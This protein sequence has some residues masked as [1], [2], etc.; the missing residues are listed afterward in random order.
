MRAWYRIYKVALLAGLGLAS[1]GASHAA[2]PATETPASTPS[3]A[4]AQLPADLFDRIVSPETVFPNPAQ[5]RKFELLP[6]PPAE[7]RRSYS[8]S[9]KPQ[10]G[11]KR[12][13]FYVV[14]VSWA[15]AGYWIKDKSQGGPQT[16]AAGPN[17]SM[18]DTYVQT[19]DGLYDLRVGVA[20]SSLPNHI[21]VD[22]DTDAAAQY[23]TRR[24]AKE[25]NN[26]N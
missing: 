23:L 10:P 6:I 11:M 20:M 5:R 1:W 4:Q 18:I 16:G 15:P 9:L 21:Q 7:G 12:H 14:L 25:V 19:D 17:A 24:Y 3:E 22:F 26:I 2:P 8:Y 13:H